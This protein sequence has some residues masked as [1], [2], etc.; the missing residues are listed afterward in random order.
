MTTMAA[1]TQ[2]LRYFIH[3]D[4]DAFRMEVS[5]SLVGSAAGAA[6]E[7]WRVARP[8]ASRARLVVDI[9]YVTQADEHG[10][11]VLQAWLEQKVQIVALSP[12]ALAIENSI[13][14]A[15]PHLR[16]TPPTLAG[17]LAFL[18]RR[19]TAGNPANAERPRISSADSK[20]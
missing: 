4:F 10:E 5:G 3:D 13:P 7:A 8:L 14:R 15:P 17:R 20:K 18:F 16:S 6:Y 11:A 19:P 2:P 1:G 12:A 9:S